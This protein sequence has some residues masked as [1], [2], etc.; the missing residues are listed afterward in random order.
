MEPE[1]WHVLNY[2]LMT[3]MWWKRFVVYICIAYLYSYQ[4]YIRFKS[5]RS[6]QFLSQNFD[7]FTR[8]T[9][10]VSK[11]NAIARA[12]L[13][14]Q[15][16]TLL[17]KYLYGHSQYSKPWD[18]KCLALIA[19]MVRAFG[20]NRQG[21]GDQVTLGSRHFLSQKLWHFYK[22]IHWC[23]EYECCCPRTVNNSNVNFTS[24]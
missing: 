16:L 20:M 3:P 21:W 5:W 17:Q 1:S 2:T 4:G 11:M 18:S 6:R 9:F 19:Q 10:R 14:F 13:T 23:V 15:M 24:K 12:Q 7:T 8:T 22:N